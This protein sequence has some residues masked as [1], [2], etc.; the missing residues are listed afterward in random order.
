MVLTRRSVTAIIALGPFS[1]MAH[2]Q[3]TQ[4]SLATATP[5]GGFPLFG[6][7][8]AAVINETDL[9]LNVVTQNTAGSAENIR[10]LEQGKVDLRWSPASRPMRPSAASAARHRSSW[11]WRRSIPIP[12]CSPCAATARRNP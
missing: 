9:T 12:A 7:N 5:G 4:V 2:A 6:D 8:A 10:L 1:R 3:A 11:W